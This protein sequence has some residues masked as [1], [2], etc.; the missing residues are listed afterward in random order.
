[1]LPNQPP[2]DQYQGKPFDFSGLKQNSNT[3]PPTTKLTLADKFG[4]LTTGSD[5]SADLNR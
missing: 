3:L 4:D 1:M 5:E 2:S